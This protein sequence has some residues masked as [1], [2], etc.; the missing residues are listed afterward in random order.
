M[1]WLDFKIKHQACCLSNGRQRNIAWGLRENARGI[2]LVQL[3]VIMLFW[4][5]RKVWIVAWWRQSLIKTLKNKC[6][7]FNEMFVAGSEGYQN[8]NFLS[9]HWRKFGQYD[10]I[11]VSVKF[12]RQRQK[13]PPQSRFGVRYNYGFLENPWSRL[14]LTTYVKRN[15]HIP[16]RTTDRNV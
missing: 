15:V 12:W 3:Q 14:A 9:I 6:F 5:H 8:D 16:W 2:T 11:S 13:Y 1:Q 7:R 4:L 10:V